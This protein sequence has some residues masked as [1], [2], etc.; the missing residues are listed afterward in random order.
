MSLMKTKIEEFIKLID[1]ASDIAEQTLKDKP[2]F[3][4]RLNNAIAATIY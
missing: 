3:S 2:E 4:E 1:Q